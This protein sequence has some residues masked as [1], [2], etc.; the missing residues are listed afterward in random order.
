LTPLRWLILGLLFLSTVINYVDRQAL[1]VL[2]PTLREKLGLSSEDYG[3]ITTIFLAAYTIAQIPAGMWIDKIG[4][5]LGF[6]ISIIG[7]SLAAILH[8]FVRGPVGLMVCRCLLGVTEA[9]NWPAGTKAVAQWFP[10]KS[11][12]LGM[13]VFD[14]GSAVGAVI[15]PPLV[16]FLA[17]HFG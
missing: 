8:A 16:A 12:A 4:T 3:L 17:L 9:G 7:W 2:L 10:Q 6:C 14:S 1:S 13:A 11:R 15:A 5:R